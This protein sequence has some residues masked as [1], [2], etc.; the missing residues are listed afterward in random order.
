MSKGKY[1]N[2]ASAVRKEY[3][4]QSELLQGFADSALS[5][6]FA[7]VVRDMYISDDNILIV[8]AITVNMMYLSRIY[9]AEIIVLAKAARNATYDE[10]NRTDY[11]ELY[12]IHI[13]YN[14]LMIVVD[15]LRFFSRM[16]A[17]LTSQIA[18]TY[19]TDMPMFVVL[20]SF[21]FFQIAMQAGEASN[22]PLSRPPSPA[23]VEDDE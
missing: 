5:F 9:G 1:I 11:K 15:T 19:L 7:S 20:A 8:M 23:P 16:F 3:Y 17:Q 21:I 12:L 18:A 10:N 2:V 22:A 13:L 14:P 4:N 6:T